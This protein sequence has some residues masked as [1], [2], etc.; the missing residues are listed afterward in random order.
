M[1]QVL[2]TLLF[3][4]NKELYSVKW[5][6]YYLILINGFNK[7]LPI[8]VFLKI[9]INNSFISYGRIRFVLNRMLKFTYYYF[10]VKFINYLSSYSYISNKYIKYK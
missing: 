8:I 5:N 6:I 10:S 4:L 1:N 2:K 9:I 3:S 7:S